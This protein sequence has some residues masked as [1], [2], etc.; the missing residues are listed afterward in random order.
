M[1]L[2]DFIEGQLSA[3]LFHCHCCEYA[4]V[5]DKSVLGPEMRSL[6]GFKY[7]CNKARYIWQTLY[8]G[9]ETFLSKP[10]VTD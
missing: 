10:V 9:I 3:T 8:I 1:T 7:L 6:G 2:D 5:L 4:N